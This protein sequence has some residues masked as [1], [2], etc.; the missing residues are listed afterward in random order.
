MP[1]FCN[2]LETNFQVP[3]NFRENDQRFEMEQVAPGKKKEDFKINV[4]GDLLSVSY[5]SAEAQNE[6]KENE[7]WLR[8]E[9]AMQ[10]FSRSFKLD[11]TVDM[12][13]MSASYKDGILYLSLPKQ[14]KAR[15]ISKSIEVQ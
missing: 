11:D 8:R 14:E 5:E 1:A 13:H 15:R 9:Y 3:V 7:E 2:R 6:K 12:Q 4:S 10:T